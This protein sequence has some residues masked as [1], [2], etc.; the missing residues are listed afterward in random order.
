MEKINHANRNQKRAE[1]VTLVS[2]NI[3][4]E[5]VARTKE[6]FKQRLLMRKV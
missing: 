1:M 5:V 3:N 4:T 6:V 2:D